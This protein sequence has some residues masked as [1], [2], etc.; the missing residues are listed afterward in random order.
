MTLQGSEDLERLEAQLEPLLRAEPGQ[1]LLLLEQRGSLSLEA[2]QRYRELLER[3]EAQLL[4]LKQRGTIEQAPD[5]DELA[6]LRERAE[7]PLIARVAAELQSE[8][9][10]AG[11]EEQAE[12]RRLLQQALAELHRAVAGVGECA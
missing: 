12:Q 7:D 1:Q 6:Q 10:Q 5:E 4:R 11:A 3:L 8:L 2:H 9:E